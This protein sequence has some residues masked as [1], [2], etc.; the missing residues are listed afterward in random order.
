METG[1]RLLRVGIVF[2]VA[3]CTLC[4]CASE[5]VVYVKQ[6]P[7]P[8]E[9]RNVLESTRGYWAGDEPVFMAMHDV[10]PRSRLYAQS[11][12]TIQLFD[13][14]AVKVP[15]L[16]GETEAPF[17]YQ[18]FEGALIQQLPNGGAFVLLIHLAVSINARYDIKS[19]LRDYYSL[20]KGSTEWDLGRDLRYSMDG[21]EPVVSEAMY[22]F[23]GVTS[24][25]GK[26]LSSNARIF[27]MKVSI[28]SASIEYLSGQYREYLFEKPGL[29]ADS[30]S[31][32]IRQSPEY[33]F[34]LPKPV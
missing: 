11:L 17:L 3:C 7:L 12:V 1:L 29:I 20:S 24:W 23:A 15:T 13:G 30:L 8:S 27:A 9:I 21:I 14:V 2:L 32:E 19:C 22:D 31:D 33:V 5:L 4:G 34:S 18:I 28:A 26:I 10:S 6:I 16:A 25:L